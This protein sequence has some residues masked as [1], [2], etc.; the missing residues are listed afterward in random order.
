MRSFVSLLLVITILF[1]Q[2]PTPGSA[3]DSW[4]QWRG[5][6]QN[7]VAPGERYPQQWDENSGIAWQIDLPGRGGS[8]PVTAGPTTFVTAG[9]GR[10]DDA[11]GENTLLAIDTAS[12][13]VKWK[14]ALGTNRGGKHAKGSGSNPSPVV[15]GDSVFAYFRSGDLACV[16]LAGEVRW[17]IN[18]QDEFGEDTLWWDL[19][20]SP[21]VTKS[22]VVVAVMQSGPSYLIALD[23]KTGKQLWKTDR[24]LDAPEEAAQSYATPLAVEVDGK[25]V[26]AVMGADHLT[27]HSADD[28]KEIGRLGGFNPTGHKFFRSI[29]SP[30]AAGNIIVCPYARGETVTAVRMDQLIAGKGRDAIAWFRDDLG[31]DVP[32]PA[33]KDGKVYVVGDGRA[34][35]GL[36]SCLDLETGKT[37]W[38][39]QLPKSRI[40]YSSSPLVAANHLYVTAENATTYVVGPL[41]A[42]QPEVVAVNKLDDTAQFTVASPVPTGESLLL[43]S[44]NRLYRL[45]SDR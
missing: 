22:A 3:E 20:S 4:T 15:D 36:I 39:T 21:T 23:K 44:R 17:H 1:W 45:A 43:R 6:A 41:D 29:S 38:T 32:T 12:G 13:A 10:T 26:I 7:G 42:S 11:A 34:S 31:S 35:R 16:S 30:V 27:L 37:V 8:T 19:G 18:L 2:P 24:M 9:V 14:A 5:P 40:S 33:I 28:G 25:E